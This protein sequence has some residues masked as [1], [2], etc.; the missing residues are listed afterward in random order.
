MFQENIIEFNNYLN[1]ITASHN[2]PYALVLSIV[3][4]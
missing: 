2:Y 4:M 3:M 1:F